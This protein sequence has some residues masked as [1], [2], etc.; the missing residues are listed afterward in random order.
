MILSSK[1]NKIN[2]LEASL[3]VLIQKET[4]VGLS[5]RM[6]IILLLS[7]Q[8]SNKSDSNMLYVNAC[9]T[10]DA[11]ENRSSYFGAEDL[12]TQTKAVLL[13]S[14]FWMDFAFFE[15]GGAAK[16]N[17]YDQSCRVSS[18]KCVLLRWFLFFNTHP[19]S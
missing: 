17:A 7:G 2:K 13:G 8:V 15:D 18:M 11:F 5:C 6:R 12:D 14:L 10:D 19:A 3:E 16:F 4:L 1:T 9:Q